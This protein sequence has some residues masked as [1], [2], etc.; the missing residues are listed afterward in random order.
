M[1]AVTHQPHAPAMALGLVAWMGLMTSYDVSQADI[2]HRWSFNVDGSA[3]DSVGSA[4]GSL[5]NGAS[6]AGGQVFLSG[7]VMAPYVSLP[8]SGVGAININTLPNVTISAWYTGPGFDPGG[9]R[10][11]LAL[12]KKVTEPGGELHS[13]VVVGEGD[14]ADY[15]FIQPWRN[16]GPIGASRGAISDA[17]FAHEV[18]GSGNEQ[19]DGLEHCYTITAADTRTGATVR[20]YIDGFLVGTQAGSVKMRDLSNELAYI[21]RSLYNDPPLIGSVNEVRIYNQV[22]TAAQVSAEYLAGPDGIPVP[23]PAAAALAV[24]GL[25]VLSVVSRWIRFSGSQEPP[26]AAPLFHRENGRCRAQSNQ[27]NGY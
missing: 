14:G 12:G 16:G 2:L 6:V 20:Y 5:I 13:G 22:L 18:G 17:N 8:A 1:I 24:L 23:E 3:E 27:S 4:D 21:G 26:F 15:I 10:M 7:G 9:F 25:I 19:L 11:L